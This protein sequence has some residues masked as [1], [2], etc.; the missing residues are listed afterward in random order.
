M[1]Q[2]CTTL[3]ALNHYYLSIFFYCIAWQKISS[4][5]VVRLW[6][7][8]LMSAPF[9]FLIPGHVDRA[10][11]LDSRT[12]VY[13]LL[14]DVTIEGCQQGRPNW[15][16]CVLSRSRD[17]CTFTLLFLVDC[18]FASSISLV[19]GAADSLFRRGIFLHRRQG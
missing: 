17:G 6:A 12:L 10:D 7:L 16:P 4:C 11:Y 1:H 14:S 18:K 15:V 9:Y 3:F 8:T 13:G 5:L 2:I 19:A